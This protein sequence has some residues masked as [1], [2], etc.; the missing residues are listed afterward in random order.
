MSQD[1]SVEETESVAL[2]K[3]EIMGGGGARSNLIEL[4]TQSQDAMPT[5]AMTPPYD[6]Q[7]LYN[8]FESSSLLRPNI[9]A[10]KTNIDSFGHHFVPIVDLTAKE[11]TQQ[12][13]D[14]MLYES[15]MAVQSGATSLADVEEPTPEEVK[16]RK[17]HLQKVARLE[18]AR[19]RAFFS[20]VCPDLSFTEL[21]RRTRQDYE[22]TGNAWWEVIRN[23]LDDV[24]HV[25]YAP[26]INIRLLAK[27]D[28]AIQVEE[29]VQVTDITWTTVKRWRRFRRFVQVDTSRDPIFFKEYG[30]PR[31]VSRA[32]GA[33]YRDVAALM[34]E[35]P[36]AKPASELLH[37]A[38]FTPN[39]PYG[40]PRWI[41][42]LPGVLGTRELEEVNY[43][44][45]RNNVVPPLALLCS[46]GR[47]GKG[48]ATKIEE[49]I[50]EH[51]KG[52][53]GTHRILVLEAE[54]QKGAGE[55]GPRSVPKVQFVPLRDAQQSDSL[56]QNYDLRNSEKVAHSFRLPRILRGDDTKINRA[57]AFIAL[58]FAEE[59]VFEPERE[60]F[61]DVINRQ[62]FPVLGV[63]FWRYR[64][65]APVVRD[66]DKLAEMLERLVKAGI[67]LPREAREI[68]ADIFNRN[69]VDISEEWTGKPLPFTL[70]QL[71]SNPDAPVDDPPKD[72]DDADEDEPAPTPTVAAQRPPTR[73]DS[74]FLRAGRP[75]KALGE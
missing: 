20:F 24:A 63:T 43:D 40:I 47:F 15:M 56:F 48:V 33:Y 38:L 45:F 50:E 8:L 66:P 19:L 42:N 32:T 30:D 4:L 22:V 58:R 36:D 60:T 18:H 9:D 2:V 7:M 17:D 12:I 35:E 39:S 31:T 74:T 28:E 67:L 54:G 59:Q 27:D 14:A 71:R 69:F 51:L 46:G 11:S 25:Y 6:F 73:D 3:A 52:R 53:K 57:T 72:D 55:S 29:R 62:L 34:A 10:Y 16:E 44:Y 13:S 21:R 70:A 23:A 61:D 26:P 49:Y 65:N 64:S 41:S 75:Y 1:T 68:A 37:F 5:G